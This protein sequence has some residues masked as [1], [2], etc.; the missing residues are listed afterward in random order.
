MSLPKVAIVGRPNVGKSS[1]LNRLAGRRI[2]I[3]DPTPGVTRDRVT[4]II[5]LPDDQNDTPRLA[6]VTD[7]GG[8]GVY[9]ADGQRFDDAGADLS[10]LTADIEHQI[11]LATERA[12]LVL[13]V[14]DAQSGL[15]ALDHTVADLLRRM[16]AAPRVLLVANKVDDEGWEAH[17]HEASSLGLGDPVG[18]SAMSGWRIRQLREALAERLPEGVEDE[19]ESA[20]EMKLAI[21]GRRN[22]GKSTLVNALAGEPRVI[23][24]EIAGTT[25][26]S[27]D[28]RFELNGR[29]FLA[30]DTAGVRKRKSFADDIEWYAHH[31]MLRAIRRAD[32]A[33]LLIDATEEITQVDRKLARELTAQ[34][35]PTVIVINKWDK[36]A[37][38]L[39]PEQYLDYINQE[40]PGLNFA[41]IVMISA[42]TGEGVQ[43]AIAMAFNLFQQA[44]HRE[45]TARLNEQIQEILTQRGP[46]S[47]LG[48]KA[49]VLYVS[50]IGVAPPTVVMV[51]NDPRL[52][53]GRYER[54]LMNALR[55]RVPFSE[56][57]IRLIFTQRKRKS[58]SELK[59]G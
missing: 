9:T 10:A 38:E 2:S 1:L 20:A 29:A 17:A 11:R 36:V 21:V 54:Y 35:K 13:F 3:V 33:M 44:N 51:V 43:D 8:Y 31:R 23:V 22:A 30:I 59:Q 57:P 32:V 39:T 34:F 14:V 6:E 37:D 18:V 15:S 16:G 47:R 7:T 41:P 24:S 50:Q 26:D 49:K 46:T 27:V 58:L 52:F 12:D 4:A 28:V 53:E 56:V 19:N 42:A 40:L 48:T 55:D 45:P 5:E 25:R